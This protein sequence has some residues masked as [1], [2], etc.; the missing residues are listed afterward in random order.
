MREVK[1]GPFAEKCCKAELQIT[2][3][4]E[5]DLTVWRRAMMNEEDDGD[6]PLVQGFF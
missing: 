1:V 4:S 2:E 6:E 5:L 3:P